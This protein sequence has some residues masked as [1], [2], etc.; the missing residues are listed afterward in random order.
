MYCNKCG[1]QIPDGFRFCNMC[2]N[3]AR[4]DVYRKEDVARM[5]KEKRREGLEVYKQERLKKFKIAILIAVFAPLLAGAFGGIF[6]A[7]YL[8]N[9]WNAASVLLLVMTPIVALGGWIAS[10]VIAGFG[11]CFHMMAAWSIGTIHIPVIPLNVFIWLF[12]MWFCLFAYIGLPWIP[13][14]NARHNFLYYLDLMEV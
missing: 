12:A 10:F 5:E 8:L 4:I 2:G 3:P 6:A 14:L 9:G 1:T 13:I 11:D 7:V